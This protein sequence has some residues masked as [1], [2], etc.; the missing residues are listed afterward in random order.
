LE[1]TL[2]AYWFKEEEERLGKEQLREKTRR[3]QLKQQVMEN[4]S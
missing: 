1:A 4:L 3:S 2:A